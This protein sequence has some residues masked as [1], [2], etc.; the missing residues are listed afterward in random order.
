MNPQNQSFLASPSTCR[1]Q[2]TGFK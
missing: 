1:L 2:W